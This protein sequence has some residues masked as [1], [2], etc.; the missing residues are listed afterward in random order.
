MH[1][2]RNTLIL[3]TVL[4]SSK[5]FSQFTISGEFRP[6]AEY[7]NG[8]KTLF[9]D[10]DDNAF[11]IDQRTRLNL[12]F[13]NEK[14]AT[15]FVLQDV[16]VWGSTPQLIIGDGAL[17]SIHEAWVQVFLKDFSI[18]F[19][20]QEIIYDDHRI[21]GNVGWVQQARSHDVVIFKYNKDDLKIDLGLA[22][23]QDG[24]SLSSTFYTV[25]ASYKAFQ[26]LWFNKKVGDF[27]G[28]LLFLNN[29]K[30]GGTP[31]D[32]KTYYSQTLGPRITYKKDALSAHLVFYY[33]GG[34]E[35]NGITNKK[36][37]A[38]LVGLDVG[39]TINEKISATLGFERQSGN[40]EVTPGTKNE[41]FNPFYGTNHKF[42]GFM[43]Y[44]YLGNHI[45]SV[46]L[47][48]IYFSLNF[49]PPKVTLRSDLHFFSSAED[50]S[51]PLDGTAMDKGLGVEWDLVLGAKL[52][53]GANVNLGY[54]QMFA[55]STMEALKLK[56]G[57]KGKTQY[58]GWLMITVKP[59]FFTTAKEN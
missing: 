40:S 45:N 22:Y 15:R 17:T 55:T 47:Q 21:F 39:Y 41:A 42:N 44:F 19:G 18:K 56:G 1:I 16:R 20:R 29:G 24:A 37:N 30:Q 26:Y 31:I 12:D 8:Y 3:A 46:G 32:F 14:Y 27:G 10:F 35:P 5:A 28:S 7:R 2:F 25:P 51:N 34:R 53:N 54:S 57:N 59:Q 48:D 36:I 33:Q 13:K 6:R 52:V 49:K 43:D 23:N 58:W 11:F 4:F 38:S 9:T 50:V